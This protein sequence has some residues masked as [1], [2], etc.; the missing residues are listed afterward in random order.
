[1]PKADMRI[2]KIIFATHNKG[3]IAEV[4]S[5]FEDVNDL[6]IVS[7]EEAGVMEDV[8]E[9]GNTFASN[10]FKKARFVGCK[11][12]EW[13]MADDSGIC[14]D[15]LGGAPGVYSARWAGEGAPGHKWIEL[16]LSRLKDVPE[17]ER[18]A[19]FETMAVLFNPNGGEVFFFR[20][21]VRGSIALKPRGVPHPKLPY[22]SVFIPDGYTKTF[23]EMLEKKNELS[24]RGRAFTKL[25]EFIQRL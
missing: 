6:T 24:H 18:T 8:V 22:D 13:T 3:K 4:R 1:M 12:N 7:A 16:L 10:A 20:G 21:E 2:K 9:D 25:K 15:A 11:T 23:S 17:R 14:V 5:I 19:R